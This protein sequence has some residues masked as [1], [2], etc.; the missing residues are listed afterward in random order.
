MNNEDADYRRRS[1]RY[2]FYFVLLF[3]VFSA[4]YV[5]VNTDFDLFVTAKIFLLPALFSL[6]LGVKIYLCKDKESCSGVFRDAIFSYY[7]KSDDEQGNPNVLHVAGACYGTF[8]AIGIVVVCI[9]ILLNKDT[10]IR[11]FMLFYH[12]IGLVLIFSIFWP[13]FRKNLK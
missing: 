7:K 10:Y 2:L 3:T 12:T 1:L 6:F 8:V 4:V 5:L 13:F 9:L 11:N